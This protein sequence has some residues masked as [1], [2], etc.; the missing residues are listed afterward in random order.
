[1]AKTSMNVL[2]LAKRIKKELLISENGCVTNEQPGSLVIG[3][4]D[5]VYV[6]YVGWND[7]RVID[8]NKKE[9]LREMVNEFMRLG[10]VFYHD[11]DLNKHFF[12]YSPYSDEL[13]EVYNPNDEIMRKVLGWDS[14]R[15]KEE[16]KRVYEDNPK[17]GYCWGRVKGLRSKKKKSLKIDYVFV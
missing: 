10:Y 8:I 9:D 17:K 14:K 16:E 2:E 7:R 11:E 3:K 1:M 12:G 15:L 5:D 13:G 4:R 6:I